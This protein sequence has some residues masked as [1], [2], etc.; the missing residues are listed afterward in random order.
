MLKKISLVAILSTGVAGMAVAAPNSMSGAHHQGQGAGASHGGSSSVIAPPPQAAQ[1]GHQ[2]NGAPKQPGMHASYG[3][4]GGHSGASSAPPRRVPKAGPNTPAHTPPAHS[5][6]KH[7]LPVQKRANQQGS[8][9]T[10]KSYGHH[11]SGHGPNSSNG[12]HYG[13]NQAHAQNHQQGSKAKH[14]QKSEHSK[15]HS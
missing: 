12:H 7:N 11:K 2:G 3:S 14:N 5:G 13:H 4:K 10:G 9:H 6:G 1:N 15:S 8:S